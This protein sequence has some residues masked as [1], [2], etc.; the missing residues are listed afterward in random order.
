MMARKVIKR[1]TVR[2]QARN[3]EDPKNKVMGFYIHPELVSAVKQDALKFNVSV[4]FVINTA[5]AA[6]MGIDVGEK[7]YVPKNGMIKNGRKK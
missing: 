1:E 3:Y 4:S 2:Y 6:I 5:I 7:Y